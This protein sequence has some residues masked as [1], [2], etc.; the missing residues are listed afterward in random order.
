MTITYRRF[1]LKDIPEIMLMMAG[2]YTDDPT[3]K[4]M[5]GTK[6][7]STITELSEHPDKGTILIMEA[8]GKIVGYS[9]IVHFWSNEWGGNVEMIDELFV[10]ADYRGQQI[11]TDFITYLRN[12]HFNGAVALQLEVTHRNVKA[13]AL[14]ERLGFKP[15]KN[16]ILVLDVNPEIE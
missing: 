4:Q 7:R 12:N 14:Y 11:A 5:S 1:T 9:V 6:F 10:K 8:K 13:R 3:N 16:A 15:H 2:L